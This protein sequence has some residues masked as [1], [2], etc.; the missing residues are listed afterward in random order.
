VSFRNSV[1]GLMKKPCHLEEVMKR[2]SGK[3]FIEVSVKDTG[4]G[5]KK[6]DLERIFVQFEQIE[7]EI[8]RRY[9]G[10]GLGLALTQKLIHLH[11]G[12]IWAESEGVGRG[13][14]FRFVLLYASA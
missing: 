7:S 1:S 6:E 5:I 8:N 10:T 13:S 11:K 9:Q 12:Y 2:E 3:E 4:I 14:T